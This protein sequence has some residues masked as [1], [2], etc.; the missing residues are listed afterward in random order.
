MTST[1]PD[2]AVQNS[3]VQN[4]AV[5][6][7][8][9]QNSTERNSVDAGAL[10][11]RTFLTL[12]AMGIGAMSLPERA[13]AAM[14]ISPQNLVEVPADK[15]ITAEV[16]A[17]LTAR[18]VPTQVTGA[19]ALAKIGMPVSG[20][21]TGQVY[22]AGDGRLWLWD[23]DSQ[24]T[25]RPG[26]TDGYH[27]A[28]PLSQASPFRNGFAVQVSEEGKQKIRPL[29]STGFSD[30]SF[31]GQYPI[32][33]VEYRDA[34]SPLA[35]TLEALSP[36]VPTAFADSSIP[37][38]LVTYTLRNTGR[39][40]LTAT[41]AGWL[42]SPV[43][44]GARTQQ[45]VRLRGAA[46]AAGSA[47]GVE[48]SGLDGSSGPVQDDIVFEDWERETYAPWTV[49]GTAF[50]AGPVT[51]TECPDYFKRFGALGITGTRFVTSHLFRGANGDIDAADRPTGKLTSPTFTISR[52]YVR[53]NVGGGGWAGGTCVN[54]VV[55][56]QVVASFTGNN[57]ELLSVKAA[58]VHKHIGKTAVIQIVDNRSGGWAHVNCD[59][60]TFSDK[61]LMP[62]D[63][64]P[65]G[66]TFALAALNSAARA[67]PS[68]ADATT[69]DA[70]F[71][72]KPG[73]TEVNADEQTITGAVSV[74]VQLRPGQSTSVTFVLSW[75]FP[76]LSQNY[77]GV[78]SYADL[79]KHY[80]NTFSSAQ[81]VAAHAAGSAARLTQQTRD[82]VKTWYTDSTMPHWFLERT[83][84]P[85]STL[86][87]LTCQHFDSG[88]F[89]ADE[90][91]YCCAGTCEH[92][93]AY[94]HSVARLF[95]ELEKSA[96]ELGDL[97]PGYNVDTGQMGFRQEQDLNWAADG[98]AA[99][100]L[101]MYREHQMSQDSSF[102]RRV[103]PKTKKSVQ[104]MIGQ[105]GADENGAGPDGVLEGVQANT[106]DQAWFGKIP[107]ITGL[108]VAM[109]QAAAA[110]ATEM[111][112]PAFAT[113]CRNIAAQG[114]AHLGTEMWSDEYGY[115]FSPRDPAHPNNLN[116]NRGCYIDQLH[117]QEYALQLGLPRVFDKAKTDTALTN[118]YKNNFMPDPAGW[119]K[120]H[121]L[122]GNPRVFSTSG[123]AGTLMG[124]WPFGNTEVGGLVGYLDEV[125]T[126]QEYQ[127]AAHLMGEGHVT[128]GLAVT[129]AIHD[130]Y[131]AAKRNPYNEVEC[132]DH[133]AR[134]MNSHAVY[135]AA[136]GY[137]YHGP[138]GKLG[139]A[140]QLSPEKFAGAFTVAA[141]WGLYKQTRRSHEQT[142][143]VEL[144][145][146]KLTLR[147]FSTVLAG[148]CGSVAIS[149]L[150]HGR[151]L[152]TVSGEL[153]KDGE[154]TVIRFREAVQMV[155]GDEL[156]I[157]YLT[158]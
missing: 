107:W 35:V 83:F 61:P 136:C 6:E 18:G 2:S 63:Q 152:R 117:G 119:V 131:A 118:I 78:Q 64:L 158:R 123:E 122:Y 1:E 87:T 134:A 86:A 111:A 102:L 133:Y 73:P 66:G 43:A 62:Y 139:F 146:G 76:R 26:G 113:T 121:G 129:R 5:Q 116:S 65:D 44:L 94:A 100:I 70:I 69:L 55:D 56:G 77:A 71:A 99:T 8:A 103:W 110:M 101:R 23:V 96:R 53:V 36:F 22:L 149:V 104:F 12:G 106:D 46:F 21:C 138:A 50:G 124:S 85:A 145:Y 105:D 34:A 72:G 25:Y 57:S 80:K 39:R 33:K 90:G 28:N 132:S 54:V 20:V 143:S 144:R 153:G 88:R 27:Y 15:G 10:S 24:P 81:N 42:D 141:G 74:P 93:W 19:A 125:W 38:T 157:I 52:R 142:S 114:T 68:I 147:S 59:R 7:S 4:S 140:P 91:I 75:F 120:T 45:A 137:S 154:Q 41:L 97:G 148:T 29:D 17:G 150:R 128:E 47:R 3:A 82:W 135:L 60:I 126:G 89:Y 115:F 58:D 92:V 109:L 67:V 14:G 51:E 9:E 108:Y 16:A 31:V 49:E 156:T 98:Q 112:D 130:R 155:A 30:V 151:H 13:A 37:A 84:A 48:F 11:R 40:T 127:L 79:R 95:P 32:G